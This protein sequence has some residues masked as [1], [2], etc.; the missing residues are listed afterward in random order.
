MLASHPGVC[1]KDL[2]LEILESAA[3][4]DMDYATRALETVSEMGFSFA[5][6]D[7]GTGYSSLSYFSKLPVDILKIDQN[8]VRDMLADPENLSI[9]E[10][11]IILAK[12]FNR[13]A[14]AEGVESMEHYAMLRH[15]GCSFGQG[16]GI[17][18]PMSQDKIPVWIEKWGKENAWLNVPRIPLQREDVVLLV[19]K[20]CHHQ[21]IDDVAA[22]ME[23]PDRTLHHL[24]NRQCRFG[25]WF[26]GN[27]YGR[28]GHLGGY[29]AL[30]PAYTQINSLVTEM[31]ELIAQGASQDAHA[32][33][34]ELYSQRD[35]F[36]EG[37]DALITQL[38]QVD[39]GS[40]QAS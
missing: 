11:I 23:N 30:Q 27:G 2:E 8:F 35:C 26:L 12:A 24:H 4:S 5:L 3:I 36:L 15:L 9:V 10:S 14:V 13:P 17:A 18:R 25:R 37:M 6:D 19:A 29:L 32:R 40:L 33:L 20:S 38:T 16:Y 22:R 1:P 39:C 34:S 28:Y 7:F 21:W 31:L